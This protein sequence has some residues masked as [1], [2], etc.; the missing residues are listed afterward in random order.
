MSGKI[1]AQHL[2]RR[3]CVY[4]RQSTLKQVREHRE[5]TARQY[6][7]RQRALELGWR[8]DRIEVV[9]S[10]LGQSGASAEW[11]AGFQHVAEQ[12]AHGKV[13]AIFALEVSRFARSSSDW[14]RLLE[15]CSLADVVIVD[16]QAIYSPGDFNDRLLL[17]LKGTMSEAEQYWMRLR[18]HGGR[19]NK[20]QR[21]EYFQ[22]PPAGYEW[23]RA[24]GR[25][26]LDPDEQVQRAAQLVFERFR[27]DR[28][29]YAVVRYFSTNGL[30]LPSREFGTHER[31]VRWIRPRHASILKML[32][33]PTYAGAYVFG[34]SEERLGLVDGHVRRR[35]RKLLPMEAWKVCLRDRHPAY[36]SWEEYLANRRQLQDNR[37]SVS[38]PQR[39]GAARE[40]SALLQGLALCGRC[41]H[42]MAVRYTAPTQR[43]GYVCGTGSE[44]FCWTVPAKTIDM[45]IARLLL[46]ALSPP[47][48]E[49]G[50]AVTREVERQGDEIDRQWQLRLD[51]ARYEAQLAERRY[52]AVDPDNRVV[53]R[54]LEREWEERLR[55]LER[56]E[57]ERQ[58]RRREQKLDLRDEDRARILALSKDLAAVWGARTTTHAD[59]KNL[60]RMVVQ[61]VTLSPIDI[62]ERQ[63]RVQLLWR[64]GAV[65]ELTVARKDKYSRTATP[66][67]AVALIRQLAPTHRDDAIAEELNRRELLTGATLKWSAPAVF[68]ARQAEGIRLASPRARH[69]VERDAAGRY[70]VHGVAT[71]L[72]VKP[73]LIRYWARAGVLPP[74]ERGGPGRPHW[75]TLDKAALHHL[76]DELRRYRGTHGGAPSA[77][78]TTEGDAL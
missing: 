38:S 73:A 8:D 28:S 31:G 2:E 20:A 69:V 27:L 16:E 36:I 77:R 34:R 17:G 46:Q 64:T 19:I 4:L 55:D 6:A 25:Y 78:P 24:G 43:A 75:F 47:E 72:G 37:T 1:L 12:V 32:H 68:R 29:A 33:N 14:H 56:I 50:L 53:A 70:T 42:R 26:R 71:A 15:L 10:D 48:V 59:R 23:D 30:L 65:S 9:D 57:L 5:S 39:R 11:R 3:A 61:E 13:G 52:K 74:T 49:L 60:L 51:R 54:S 44:G 76:R 7:L 35:H 45:A 63:T 58:E 18:L 41:G 40:G 66:P 22:L 21:G 67:E 62:P